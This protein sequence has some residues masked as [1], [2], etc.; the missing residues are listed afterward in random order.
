MYTSSWPFGTV[1]IILYL[2]E[3]F[4]LLGKNWAVHLTS[5]TSHNKE[6][7]PSKIKMGK[8]STS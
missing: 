5:N 3:T 7:H 1:L 6:T 2:L 4:S 8:T